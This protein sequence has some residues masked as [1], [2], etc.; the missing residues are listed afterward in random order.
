MIKSVTVAIGLLTFLPATYGH[1]ASKAVYLNTNGNESNS[2]A[3]FGARDSAG[4]ETIG[5]SSEL[6]VSKLR[7][8]QEDAPKQKRDIEEMK[9]MLSDITRDNQKLEKRNDEL[10]RNVDELARSVRSL[11]SKL[12]DLSRKIK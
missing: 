7:D 2:V 3:I 4:N 10:S 11:E 12:D 1:A 5:P 9:K 8:I 6:R